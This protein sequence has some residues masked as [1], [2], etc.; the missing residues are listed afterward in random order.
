ML[1]CQHELLSAPHKSKDAK[2]V[3]QWSNPDEAFT[4]I[5]QGIRTAVAELQQRNNTQPKG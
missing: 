2:S 4:H 5:A 1:I 3:T